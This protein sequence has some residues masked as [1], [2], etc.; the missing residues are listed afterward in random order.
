LFEIFGVRC[1]VIFCEAAAIYGVIVTIILQ[2]KLEEVKPLANGN[3]PPR[4]M[5]SG[6]SLLAAGLTT[7]FANL[8]CGCATR[9]VMS[10]VNKLD[11]YDHAVRLIGYVLIAT[12]YR[13]ANK[14]E[15]KCCDL[16]AS[17]CDPV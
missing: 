7:G 9:S 15:A 4:A 8:A 11:T 14:Y 5:F 6:Y 12:A 3:W 2:T 17:E 1:S 13:G 16:T 10:T